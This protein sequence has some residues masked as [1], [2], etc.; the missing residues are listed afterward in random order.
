MLGYQIDGNKLWRIG[1]GKSTRACAR[2][3]C[4]T[5]NEAKEMACL[6]HKKNG[7]FGRDLIKISLLD[8]I[9]SPKLDKSITST[10][11]ECRQCKAFGGQHLAALLKLITQRHPW[12][13]LVGNYLSMPTGK[14]RFHTMGLYMDVYS[15]KVFGFKFTMYSTTATTTASLEM[16]CQ[17]YHAPEVFMVDGGS[18]FSGHYVANWCEVHSLRYHQVTVYSPWVNGLFEGTNGKLLSRLKRLCAPDLG[19]DEWAKV[20]SFDHLPSNWPLHFD[21]AIERLNRQI[22]PAY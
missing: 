11:I 1:D 16:I 4:I 17:T 21:V 12:E 10:I 3:E 2:L 7:H 15:Q 5:Q 14:G 19:E 13:L 8:K 22:L 6:K 20:T 18:H 9:C